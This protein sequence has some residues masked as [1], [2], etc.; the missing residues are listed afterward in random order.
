MAWFPADR[1]DV[2]GWRLDV[3]SLL[4]ILGESLMA[5]H[6]QPLSA[7]RLCLLPRLL[8]APQSFLGARPNRLPTTPAIVC[9]VYSGTMIHELNYFAETLLPIDGLEKYQVAVYNIMWT[10]NRKR[11]RRPGQRLTTAFIPRSLRSKSQQPNY[12]TPV[13]PR[14]LSP[15]NAVTVVSFLLTVGAFIGAVWIRDG[16]AVLALVAMSLASTLIGLA[17][18]WESD[19][20]ARPA[21]GPVPEG[22]VVIR[23]RDGAFVIIQCSEEIARELYMGPEE[24]NYLVGGQWFT[25][26]VGLSMFLVIVS[27]L[28]L[29]NCG[30]TMQAVITGIYIVLNV[31]YW[32]TSLLPQNWYW[33][34]SR[35][36]CVDVTPKHIKSAH[37]PGPAGER[38]SYTRSLGYAIQATGEV[39]WVRISGA[40]PK[41]TAWD[42]WLE[43]ARANVGNRDWDAVGEKDRLMRESLSRQPSRRHQ[44]PEEAQ[45]T[46]PARR[47][48][49]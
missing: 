23:T 49:A 27:V 29:G 1:D 38:P 11:T 2:S 45:I 36:D 48:T 44:L 6:V 34:M 18:H 37:E 4:A 10:E 42:T 3:V 12:E 13:P 20:A 43:L 46:M 21:D 24:C 39:G 22:D 28:L 5:R 41:T 40:A 26:L 8:P 19:L 25:I 16:A 9:G 32:A 7:S 35:Y 31:L 17:L 14:A 15:I 47:G 30:W 33:D